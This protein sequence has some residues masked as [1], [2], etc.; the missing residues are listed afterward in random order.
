[1][2]ANIDMGKWVGK[3]VEIIKKSER[4]TAIIE[5]MAK[6]EGA[7]FSGWDLLEFLKVLVED[8]FTVDCLIDALAEIVDIGY[9]AILRF[10]LKNSAKLS[11][12]VGQ[13]LL[14]G[15]LGILAVKLGIKVRKGKKSKI[16]TRSMSKLYSM[17]VRSCDSKESCK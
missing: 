13:A 10:I 12:G 6:V 16:V 3:I 2:K 15:D 7:V 5:R 8:G 11:P 17:F 14:V 1:M 4:L 9:W